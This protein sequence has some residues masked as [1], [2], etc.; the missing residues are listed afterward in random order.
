MIDSVTKT[1]SEYRV[2]FQLDNYYTFEGT[3]LT[4]FSSVSLPM[5]NPQ[6]ATASVSLLLQ[7]GDSVR[8]PSTSVFT[9]KLNW[10]QYSQNEMVTLIIPGDVAD[11]EPVVLIHQWTIDGAGKRKTNRI[12]N[13]TMTAVRSETSGSV[14]AMFKDSN[15][16]GR[17]DFTLSKASN[18][19]ML[20]MTNLTGQRDLSAPYDLKQTDFRDLRK[21]KVRMLIE[22]VSFPLIIPRRR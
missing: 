11:G 2:R 3:V 14:S 4:D 5:S 7:R 1:N 20:R 8:V 16:Y 12:V 17:Y 13:G 6:G 18:N 19:L 9:G 21:Q 22:N 15:N 10:F